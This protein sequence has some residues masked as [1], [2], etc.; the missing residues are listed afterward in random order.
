MKK[1][2]KWEKFKVEYNH[3]MDELGK[4]FK[5]LTVKNTLDRPNYNQFSVIQ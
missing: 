4:A 3:D 5:D 1:K 2:I